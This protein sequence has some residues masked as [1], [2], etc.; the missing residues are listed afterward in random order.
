VITSLVN[1]SWFPLLD[2]GNFVCDGDTWIQLKY[3][4]DE[5]AEEQ[6]TTKQVTEAFG[7]RQ[8]ISLPPFPIGGCSHSDFVCCWL[9][10]NVLAVN[11]F[12]NPSSGSPT[13]LR[14]YGD[15]VMHILDERLPSA[16]RVVLPY[17]HVTSPRPWFSWFRR[18]G[19]TFNTTGCYSQMIITPHAAYVPSF[20]L[21]D[22]DNQAVQVVQ[23]GMPGHQSVISVPVGQKLGE[24]GGGLH[25]M[26]TQLNGRPAFEFLRALR[27]VLK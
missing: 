4:E 14:E 27:R 22:T 2:G 24:Y 10:H 13:N 9:G 23:E 21:P 15:A 12:D 26:T 25:C 19:P 11:D 18:G 5:T 20:G 7:L 1:P 8:Q 16:R 6:Q 3:D 17:H